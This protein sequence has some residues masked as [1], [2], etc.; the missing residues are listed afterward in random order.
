MATFHFALWDHIGYHSF[1]FPQGRG[2]SLSLHDIVYHVSVQTNLRKLNLP[3]KIDKGS[4]EPLPF[5]SPP[6]IGRGGTDKSK[7]GDYEN[8][9]RYV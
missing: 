8:R 9:L 5:K 4:D 1:I 2:P 3:G 7:V 6:H